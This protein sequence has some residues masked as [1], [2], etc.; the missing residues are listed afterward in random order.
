MVGKTEYFPKIGDEFNAL[1]LKYGNVAIG[2][3]CKCL[4]VTINEVHAIDFDKCPR[5]FKRHE[6]V[7]GKVLDKD[8]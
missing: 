7:F 5:A 1:T 3:P 6:F 4:K 8:I 2:G